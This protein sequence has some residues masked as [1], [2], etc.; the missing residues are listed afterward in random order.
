M[1]NITLQPVDIKPTH[2]TVQMFVD[3]DTRKHGFCG[4]LSFTRGEF[5][6]FRGVLVKG[7]KNNKSASITI[8][9]D[10]LPD[11]E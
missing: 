10:L 3:S 7:V 11:L 5:E 6:D 1:T 4:M 9:P 8:H 2:V